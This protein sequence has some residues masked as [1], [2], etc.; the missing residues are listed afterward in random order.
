MQKNLERV[1]ATYIRIQVFISSPK[2]P[3]WSPAVSAHANITPKYRKQ[4]EVNRIFFLCYPKLLLILLPKKC[5]GNVAHQK[6]CSGKTL[7]W[8]TGPEGQIWGQRKV[9]W[10]VLQQGHNNNKSTFELMK[11]TDRSRGAISHCMAVVNDINQWWCKTSLHTIIIITLRSSLNPRSW[12]E[13]LWQIAH[14][15]ESLTWLHFRQSVVFGI[16]WQMNPN[17]LKI[18][19]AFTLLVYCPARTSCWCMSLFKHL[20]IK[21]NVIETWL[22]ILNWSRAQQFKP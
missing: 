10:I 2:L 1:W 8:P 6:C 7:E 22:S 16:K 19:D 13:P 3:E 20:F 14:T 11:Q 21:E 9:S 18:L 5:S 17:E 4:V 15:A 12:V